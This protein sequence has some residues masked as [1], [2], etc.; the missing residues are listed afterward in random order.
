M[1][2]KQIQK[3]LLVGLI[4]T[5]DALAAELPNSSASQALADT[6]ERTLLAKQNAGCAA[7]YA[8]LYNAAVSNNNP[9][10]QKWHRTN[11]ERYVTVSF[12]L[13]GN[14][15]KAKAELDN[16]GSAI[17]AEF[18]N[19]VV[20]DVNQARSFVDTRVDACTQVDVKT[21]DFIKRSLIERFMQ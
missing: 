16:A 7:T 14:E 15:A 1:R 20:K 13:Y 8:L 6:A 19:V 11:F 5:L 18:Q 12:R 21:M 9:V 17:R 2:A 10:N 3:V 4:I